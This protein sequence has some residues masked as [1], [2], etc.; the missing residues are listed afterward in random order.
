[1]QI[2]T[3]ILLGMVVGA[4]LGLTVGPE[5]S[6]LPHDLYKLGDA[7]KVTLLLDKDDPSTALSLPP[8][9]LHLSL[10]E[11][12]EGPV[13]D[14]SGN[15]H[16]VPV[17]AKVQFTLSKQFVLVDSSDPRNQEPDPSKR[18][19]P[20]LAEAEEGNPA[21]PLAGKAA[22]D[23]IEAYL[24]FTHTALASSVIT[25]PEPISSIGNTVITWLSPIGA[26]F[27]RLITMVIVPLVFSS[28]LVGVASLGDIRKLG[29]MGGK[30]LGLYLIT[31]ALAV[32][33]GL[34]CAH[35]VNPGQFV[36]EEDK[37]KLQSKF[38]DKAEDKAKN[39]A[40]AP[41][42]VDNLLGVVPKNP[43]QALTSGNM[44][45]I[46]FFA[47]TLGIALTMMGVEESQLIVS[48]FDK[49]QQAMVVIIHMVMAVAPFGV[50]ALIAE[51][52][53]TSGLSVLGALLIYGLTVL[54]GLGIHAFFVYGGLVRTFTNLDLRGFL[55]AIRPAQLL[56]FSTSSS[57]ATLPVSMECAEE[58]LGVSNAVSSF[59]LPLGSTVNM[60]GTA[61]YQGVAAIFIAQVFNIDLDFSAQLAIVLT[62]TMASIGA[63]GV[64]GAG[65]VTL[66][67]VLT[68]TGIP[69]VGVALILGMDRILD[70]FR[71]AVNVT[72]DL[73]VTAVMASSEGEKLE[74]LSDKA[75]AADPNR[76]FEGRLEQ[77]QEAI[78]PS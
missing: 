2:Y 3:K 63:A 77:D 26:L 32:S 36:A 54:L 69:P 65:M 4:T 37:A 7:S 74:L 27:M 71:T 14:Q 70:M 10:D 16:T 72:G 13:A 55:R 59:V 15:E 18:R 47:V 76:G 67:M 68:A 29:R 28:L 75:D 42:A 58:K 45:Q 49:I 1:M 30:T 64:P 9:A 21:G 20:L 73:S 39:A 43:V 66:A 52:V 22:G 50:A 48:F 38:E 61:L 24:V 78:P 57:S 31:T 56:A 12:E 19:L 8:V 11:V 34:I 23:V 60:D 35:V 53:G 51:V 17:R 41:S 6:F 33:I 46:I 5:S 25:A 62:A 40:E 44:L